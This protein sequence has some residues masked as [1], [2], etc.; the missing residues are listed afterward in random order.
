[1]I[2]PNQGLNQS[3]SIIE[4]MQLGK[5]TRELDSVT[6]NRVEVW[7]EKATRKPD[8]DSIQICVCHV[9]KRSPAKLYNIYIE[10][11]KIGVAPVPCQ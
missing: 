8:R 1:M 6:P 2:Q 11:G 7:P 10:F 9:L 5:E 4:L 3:A